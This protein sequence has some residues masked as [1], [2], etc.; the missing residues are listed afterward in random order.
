MV[1]EQ[2]D[3][4]VYTVRGADRRSRPQLDDDL[5][6]VALIFLQPIQ[7]MLKNREIGR[8]VFGKLGRRK[9][10]TSAW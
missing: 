9:K 3:S 8:I 6:V 7:G 5:R 4:L 2:R 10:G 1:D